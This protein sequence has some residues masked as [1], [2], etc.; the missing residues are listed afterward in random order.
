MFGKDMLWG[1]P[2]PGKWHNTILLTRFQTD[3]KKQGCEWVAKVDPSHLEHSAN[4]L[5]SYAFVRSNPAQDWIAQMV[6]FK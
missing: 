4:L 3:N 5:E 2:G 6:A 1:T